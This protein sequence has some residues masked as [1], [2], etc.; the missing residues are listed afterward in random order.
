MPEL[1]RVLTEDDLRRGGATAGPDLTPYMDLIDT[2]REQGGVGGTL[3]L[4]EGESQRTEKRRMSVA[5]K[6]RGFQLTWRKAPE[7]RLR[8]VLAAPGQPAPGARARRT[9]A[10][11]RD[12]QLTIDAVMTEDVAQVTDTTAAAEQEEPSP[13]PRRRGRR[14]AE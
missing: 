8:F 2:I 3:T 5:A 11:R 6:E 7:G 13:S 14:K 10:E 4:S 12:E 9:P 1:S